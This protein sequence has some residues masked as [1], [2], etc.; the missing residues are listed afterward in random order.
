MVTA[1]VLSELGNAMT[2]GGKTLNS[3]QLSDGFAA[4]VGKNLITGLTRAT[5]NSAVAGTDLETS[6][7][8]EVVAGILGAA[9]AQG[10]NWI[11]G[12]AQTGA[13]NEFGRAFAHAVAGCMAGAAG[14]SAPGSDTSAGSG[15]GAGA[16]GAVVGELSAQLYGAAD[17]AK[18]VAFASMVSGIAAAVAGQGAQGADAAPAGRPEQ[19]RNRARLSDARADHRTA[20][21][22]RQTHV[23][24]GTR[25][26]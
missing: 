20:H 6:I 8:T 2:I 5:I 11:G 9:S 23:E 13:I 15:C 7:R 17:P 3:V 12:Q 24:C 10:A 14:A 1:G 25:T 21:R 22:A 18:T 16:L 19:Q 4:N 26:V